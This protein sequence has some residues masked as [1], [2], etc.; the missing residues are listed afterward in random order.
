M[1]EQNQ[2]LYLIDGTAYVYRA[3]H[4]FNL[5][6]ADGQPTG[7]V[8]GVAN[9]I[10]RIIRDYSPDYLVVVFDAKG[11]TFRDDIYQEYKANR[12]PMPDDL[13]TQYAY[14]RELVDAMGIKS[15]SISDV[16]AD[17]V[18]GTLAVE[19]AQAGLRTFIASSD[20][21]LAQLVTD[22]ISMLDEQKALILGPTQ[23]KEKFGVPPDQIVDYLS[24]VGDTSDNI[25]G[26]PLVGKKT[27]ANWLAKHGSLDDIIANA[28]S[29]TGK[30]GENLRNSLDTLKLARQLVTLKLDVDVDLDLESFRTTAGDKEKLRELYT[31]LEFKSWLAALDD[32]G[33]E[34]E[35]VSV[36]YTAVTDRKTFDDLIDRLSNCEIFAFDTETT[37]FDMRR[38]RL[39]GISVAL[40][41]NEAFYIPVG[42]QYPDVQEQLDRDYVLEKIR[43]P[44]ESPDIAKIAQNIKF[45]A[46]V[47]AKYGIN[48][49]GPFYDTM[50]ESYVMNSTAVSKHS[51]DNLAL[52]YLDHTTIKYEDVAGKK[53][54]NQ[55]T[56]DQVEIATATDYAAEDADIALRLHQ[57]LWPNIESDAKLRT[58]FEQIDMPLAPVL[59]R[60]EDHGVK[61]DRDA[62]AQQSAELHQEMQLIEQKIFESAGMPFNISSPKQIAEVLFNKLGLPVASKTSTGQ[63]S[64]SEAVL[65]DLAIQY[66]VPKWILEHRSL[67]KLK[68]TYTDKLP[69]MIDHK[70]GRVHTSYHQ[71]VA[72]T[73]RLSSS[74]PNLQNIPIRT[75]E[76]R[77]IRKAFI[78][79]PGC[80]LIS[81]DYS[82]I[83]LR[84]MAHLSEDPGLLDAFAKGEDV[85]RFTAAEVFDT[86]REEVTSDQ[87]RHA[88]AI[89]FGLMYGMSPYGLSRQLQIDV[90]RAQDYVDQYF[91][92]YP[93]VRDFMDS[94][95][96]TARTRRYVET[97]FGRR[98]YLADINSK[99]FGRR[100]HA[101]RTAINAPLQGTA[102]DI[103][104]LAMIE[105]DQWIQQSA[106]SARMIMQVHDEL[107]LEVPEAEEQSVCEKVKSIMESAAELHVPLVADAGRGLNWASAH[108]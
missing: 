97:L 41:P 68:S 42:H 6:T 32:D 79:E 39:V 95:R 40:Q 75:S 63:P 47:F 88:K 73:G 93:K 20:K 61:I 74:D 81:I 103:I 45:D 14:I 44:L 48:V 96:E 38:E 70:T 17:D 101:E 65:S 84:I 52:K 106:S 10:N 1:T 22:D 36:N 108:E 100:Q 30:T 90:A 51:L 67:A 98:L 62:L 99:Q 60:M 18:I 89:N 59:L 12:P 69:E 87:R 35:K 76:G 77:R 94:T 31:K 64:T 26:V 37:G 78:A 53:G 46:V 3:F 55:L 49:K 4:A 91:S 105:V 19:A 83:E 29:F 80:I 85:H 56:F 28:E 57:K 24:L 58:V 92:R 33:G 21:D 34:Q 43:Y 72:A 9:M 15:I 27:A 82:Q 66:D 50:V 2:T 104:K 102:A 5:S 11:K 13:R 16:E 86:S 7:A 23:I 107:V 71:A 8:Y 54:K 25:P